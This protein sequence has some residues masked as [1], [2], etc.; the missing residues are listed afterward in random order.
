MFWCC[1]RRHLAVVVGVSTARCRGLTLA[2]PPGA[3]ICLWAILMSCGPRAAGQR[4]VLQ[5]R[6]RGGGVC[7]DP[8]STVLVLDAG[9]LGAGLGQDEQPRPLGS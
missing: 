5:G 2:L 1:A 4:E 6:A 7:S 8:S 9:G 3:V